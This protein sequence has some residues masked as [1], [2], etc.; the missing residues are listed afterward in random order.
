MSKI[1]KALDAIRGGQQEGAAGRSL[2]AEDSQ[3]R[4]GR[5]KYE[6]RKRRGSV[7]GN[8]AVADELPSPSV[9]TIEP[10]QHISVSLDDLASIGLSPGASHREQISDQFRRIKRPLLQTAFETRFTVGDNPNVIMMASALPGAGKSF[11]AL[12][13]A[14]SISMERDTGAVLVDADVLKP[15]ISRALGLQD[16]TGLIDYLLDPEMELADILVQT[17]LQDIVVIPAGHPHPESTELLASRRMR[18]L[19]TELAQ[20]YGGRVVVFDTPPLLIT[21]E[22]QVLARNMGQ[23]VF[24]IEARV[25]SQESALRAL[26]LLDRDKPINAIL[27]KSKSANTFGYH[28]DDY[29]YYPYHTKGDKYKKGNKDEPAGEE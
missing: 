25:S 13:L 14:Q 7:V 22:A 23:I 8:T 1:Q 28:S 16:K 20:L 12:N 11:C 4:N 19:V 27:N 21:N 17:D 26:A 29:G 9:E 15:N 18:E 24:V 2:P 5:P 3:L 10:R 6:A